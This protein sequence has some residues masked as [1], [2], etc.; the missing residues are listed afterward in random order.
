MG[1]SG[2]ACVAQCASTMYMGLVMSRTL[3]LT[4]EAFIALDDSGMGLA[5]TPWCHDP[6]HGARW[7]ASAAPGW[8]WSTEI[9]G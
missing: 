6:L 9:T 7:A 5:S 4:P 1:V 2:H 3:D 8:V